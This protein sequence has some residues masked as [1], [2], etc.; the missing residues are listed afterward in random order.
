M[1]TPCYAQV[2]QRTRD[3]LE[4]YL[5]SGNV[6]EIRDG[7]ISVAYWEDDWKWA[8]QELAKFADYH[9]LV[10]WAVATGLGFLAAFNGQI[11]EAAASHILT[12]LKNHPTA[13]VKNAAEEAQADIDHFVKSRRED[14]NI[15]LAKRLPEGWRPPEG[16]FGRS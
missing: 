10:L 12:R 14:K 1:N 11:D 8:Q 13:S 3:Q 7:L 16:H 4:A 5:S 6:N 9:D 2:K 15:D